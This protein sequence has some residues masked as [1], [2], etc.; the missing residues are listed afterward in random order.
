MTGSSLPPQVRRVVVT[1]GKVYYP[2]AKAREAA[3]LAAQVPILRAEQ[4]YP[5]PVDELARVLARCPGLTEVVWAQEEAQ[6]HGAWH[7]VRDPLEAALPKGVSLRYAG[8]PPAAPCAVCR[9]GLH[10]QEERALVA[11]ALG[12]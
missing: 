2:L 6:N 4:L 11:Q 12:L 1:S 8:R 5:F 10:A 9:Q 7:L 3:G